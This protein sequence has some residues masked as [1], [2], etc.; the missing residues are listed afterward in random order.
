MSEDECIARRFRQYMDHK[1]M[2]TCEP[3]PSQKLS[4]FSKELGEIV[5][6]HVDFCIRSRDDHDYVQG[7]LHNYRDWMKLTELVD[8]VDIIKYNPDWIKTFDLSE[9]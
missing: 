8:I 4:Y 2:S 6:G 9:Y 5:I 1:I 3:I 7:T